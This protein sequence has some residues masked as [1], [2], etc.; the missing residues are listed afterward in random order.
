MTSMHGPESR[1]LVCSRARIGRDMS[2]S[3]GPTGMALLRFIVL[4]TIVHWLLLSFLLSKR[5][6]TSCIVSTRKLS[7][8][9][10]CRSLFLCLRP[11]PSP[12]FSVSTQSI[13]VTSLRFA[14]IVSFLHQTPLTPEYNSRRTKLKSGC[15]M[16]R[17]ASFKSLRKASS[18]P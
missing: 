9:V 13:P 10:S 8:L 17:A 14:S 11:A 5:T 3:P 18:S 4:F 15:K 2:C 12:P 1:P 6:N 7:S 16:R